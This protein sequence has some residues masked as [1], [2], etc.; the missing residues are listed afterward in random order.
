[1]KI[2]LCLCCIVSL[3][4]YSKADTTQPLQLKPGEK[5]EL[6]ISKT[7]LWYD[8]TE[9][10]PVVRK[11]VNQ[12]LYRFEV[13]EVDRKKGY[14]LK[15]RH[16]N[17]DSYGFKKLPGDSLWYE[18]QFCNSGID[19]PRLVGSVTIDF[20]SQPFT[21][22]LKPDFHIPDSLKDRSWFTLSLREAFLSGKQAM[23]GV[24]D[25]IVQE[26]HPEGIGF[27]DDWEAHYYHIT[28]ENQLEVRFTRL[29]TLPFSVTCGEE[30]RQTVVWPGTNTRIS[31]TIKQ[32]GD[33]KSVRITRHIHFPDYEKI[34]YTVPLVDGKF[35]FRLPLTAPES[36]IQLFDRYSLF[37]EPGDDL[38]V[39][40]NS[41]DD[42]VPGFS[43]LGATNN[44]YYCPEG[45]DW[46]YSLY[47][48]DRR[49]LCSREYYAV[50]ERQAD[51]FR[52]KLDTLKPVLTPGFYQY[53]M[54]DFKYRT[55]YQKLMADKDSTVGP[56]DCIRNIEICN[57][58]ALDNDNYMSTLR[59][60]MLFIMPGRLSA[61]GQAE[62]SRFT[63]YD[64]A[65]ALLDG[66]VLNALLVKLIAE[67]M[68]TNF[69]R[70]R[71]M[72]DR[73]KEDYLK[74][75]YTEALD[76]VYEQASRLAPG[77][78]APGFTLTDTEGR[79]VSLSDFRG[80]VVYIDFWGTGCGPCMYEFKNAA[81]VLEEHFRDCDVVFL[82]ISQDRNE[83]VWKNTLSEFKIGGINLRDTP[84]Q[85]VSKAYM[86]NGIPHYVLIGRDGKIINANANRPSMGVET[87]LEKALK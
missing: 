64:R 24:Q 56:V 9:H 32:P 85:K 41:L 45:S 75:P 81:P 10:N 55:A 40:L 27:M 36:G 79:E 50:L 51:K 67:Q 78:V 60:V 68:K 58:L 3:L 34:V 35:E 57:P 84:D 6:R 73:Y 47:K 74:S 82:K 69:V 63:Y 54:E 76:R 62:G 52:K 7:E 46:G 77:S 61:M 33:L 1:M 20:N 31:G 5:Y 49:K 17:T 30:D 72:Y 70:Y 25:S 80:K 37:L 66:K 28:R 11:F 18:I 53:M 21:L 42:R 19:A 23:Y 71:G 65:V 86:V 59:H 43:G 26:E 13:K 48:I 2:I 39:V 12:D 83:Q 16:L 87:L 22:N 29:D 8:A 38:T 15:M 4:Q 14:T 44:R